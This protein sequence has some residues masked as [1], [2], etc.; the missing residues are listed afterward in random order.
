MCCGQVFGVCKV[1]WGFKC[2]QYTIPVPLLTCLHI[3]FALH[4]HFVLFHGTLKTTNLC[5]QAPAQTRWSQEMAIDDNE[6]LKSF[7]SSDLL[8]SPPFPT[9]VTDM[10]PSLDPTQ[11]S[12]NADCGLIDPQCLSSRY[13]V[14]TWNRGLEHFKLTSLSLRSCWHQS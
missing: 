14:Q 2:I 10:V 3:Y 7:R 6:R 11:Y 1:K 8:N 4:E 13:G 9:S 5:G 12:Q